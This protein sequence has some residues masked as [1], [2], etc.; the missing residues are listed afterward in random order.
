MQLRQWQLAFRDLQ[1]QGLSRFLEA[2]INDGLEAD[3]LFLMTAEIVFVFCNKDLGVYL[4]RGERIYR[5]Q[6]TLLPQ[7]NLSE[8]IRKLDFYAFRPRE[9]D[10]F[11][12]ID[13][14]FIDLFMAEELEELFGD[15]KSVV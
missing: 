8:S 1:I 11:L 13:P 2:G 7:L 14:E 3:F 10:N 15:R 12:I 6:P 9:N 4:P 5:Q